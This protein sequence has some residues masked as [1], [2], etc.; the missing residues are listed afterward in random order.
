MLG[1][2][3]KKSRNIDI[4]ML[5]NMF[6]LHLSY[7][8]PR[9]GDSRMPIDESMLGRSKRIRKQPRLPDGFQINLR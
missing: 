8:W 7:L 2:D 6:H 1:K 5:L 4:N 9:K 3:E